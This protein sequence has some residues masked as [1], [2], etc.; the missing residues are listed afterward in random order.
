MGV[1]MQ[2]VRDAISNYLSSVGFG[3]GLFFFALVSCAYTLFGY[4]CS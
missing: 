4:W 2:H 1:L 3:V